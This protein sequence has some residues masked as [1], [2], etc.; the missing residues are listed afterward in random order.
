M[1]EATDCWSILAGP[2]G[3]SHISLQDFETV[4][5]NERV[6]GRSAHK[7]ETNSRKAEKSKPRK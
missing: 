7:L 6:Y 1:L 5:R 3:Q 4:T 2:G